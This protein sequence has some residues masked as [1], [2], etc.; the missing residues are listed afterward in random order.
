MDGVA[1]FVE[2]RDAFDPPQPNEVTRASS[3]REGFGK[4]VGKDDD[5]ALHRLVLA[6]HGRKLYEYEFA[7]FP[8]PMLGAKKMNSGTL[9][10]SVLMLFQ[11]FWPFMSVVLFM[12][13]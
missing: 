4:L 12:G 9:F 7:T 6:S 1:Q 13:T 8:Q 5:P 3:H 11:V 2:G 10:R